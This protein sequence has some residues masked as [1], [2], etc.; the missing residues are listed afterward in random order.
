MVS[1]LD[2]WKINEIIVYD[3]YA[4]AQVPWAH[5]LHLTEVVVWEEGP[6]E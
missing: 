4:V 3:S 5:T 2:Q 6:T 1:D